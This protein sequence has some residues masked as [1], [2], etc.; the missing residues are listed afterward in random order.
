MNFAADEW[1]HNVSHVRSRLSRWEYVRTI[2]ESRNIASP[3]SSLELFPIQLPYRA[4]DSWI[5]VEFPSTNDDDT[6]F[7][8]LHDT[9]SIVVHGESA[10][11]SA[12]S[13]AGILLDEWTETIPV[14]EEITGISFN[15]NQ[16]N[17]TPPQALL[18]AVPAIEKGTWDW[19]ELVGILNDTLLRAKLRAVEPALLDK[20]NKPETGVLLPAILAN[21]SQYD[22]DLA[23]DYRINVSA[24]TDKIPI[25]TAG[26]SS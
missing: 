23:L 12:G 1:L 13:Q 18:L 10:S 8:I 15:Y 24:L 7:T 3:D 26:L 14:K 2:Y 22:L 17:A 20:I 9:L 6:P 5:A 21:F 16:P 25:Q 19:D 11:F 4:N